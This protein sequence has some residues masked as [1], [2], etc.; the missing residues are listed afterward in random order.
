MSGINQMLLDGY[1]VDTSNDE[2]FFA[3]LY[4]SPNTNYKKVPVYEWNIRLIAKP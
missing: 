3:F 2:L 1:C 4:I